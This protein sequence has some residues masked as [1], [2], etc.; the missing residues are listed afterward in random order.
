MSYFTI[1]LVACSPPK[2]LCQFVYG[3]IILNSLVETESE[4]LV[5]DYFLAMVLNFLIS[6][7]G[8]VGITNCIHSRVT[9]IV[10]LIFSCHKKITLT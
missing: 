3:R 8:F 2:L 5:N 1:F 6:K 7:N 9:Y 4:K 10:H